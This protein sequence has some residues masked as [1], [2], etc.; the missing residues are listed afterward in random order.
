[1]LNVIRES[2]DMLVLNKPT[3]IA[4]LADRSGAPCLW[5]QIKQELAPERPFLVHRLDKGT[6][7][8]LMI[9]RNQPSQ[10][11]LTRAFQARTVRKFYLAWVVGHL[12]TEHT[13]Q[14]ELPLR[15]GRKSRF[16]VAG[17]RD[18]IHRS[19]TRWRLRQPD[20]DGLHC[21]THLR[22]LLCSSERSLLL[23]RPITGRTHQLRVHLSWIGHPIMGD[24]LYGQPGSDQ[25]SAP[26]LQLH[27]HRLCVPGFGSFHALPDSGWLTAN[28]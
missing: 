20:A 24:H 12:A 27:C 10:R 13:L 14:V 21:E 7:G 5:E 23:L 15:R 25:Q 2:A 4:L 3:N 16:R 18:Q 1:M 19:G 17:Q 11:V 22:S 6:S 8:V 28:A 26:R 9:A